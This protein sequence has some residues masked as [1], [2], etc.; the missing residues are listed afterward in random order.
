MKN[1]FLMAAT[2][3]S[4][5][6]SGIYPTTGLAATRAE[7]EMAKQAYIEARFNQIENEFQCSLNCLHALRIGRVTQE[8]YQT[9]VNGYQT[10]LE[11]SEKVRDAENQLENIYGNERIPLLRSDFET[12]Y[13]RN[14]KLEGRVLERV[15]VVGN[16]YVKREVD[17]IFASFE[18][19]NN[20][21]QN[22]QL[23][24]IEE[25]LQH[26]KSLREKAREKFG[27]NNSGSNNSGLA[28]L[29]LI[30]ETLE[31]EVKQMRCREALKTA[32]AQAPPIGGIAA[33]PA[34]IPEAYTAFLEAL[35]TEQYSL[36]ASELADTLGFQL[37]S[38][39]P[40]PHPQ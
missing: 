20:K 25:S 36:M 27:S 39:A 34:I 13:A 5:L 18:I 7:K 4:L 32:L 8:A 22:Q 30:I 10:R 12:K 38:P 31:P 3:F 26:F 37:D 35:G 14:Q 9:A 19:F 15:R 1:K 40:Q 11:H 21:V 29:D 17:S 33:V 23:A 16:G 6:I 24:Q 2:T 28:G